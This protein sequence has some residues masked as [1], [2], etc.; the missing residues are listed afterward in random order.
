MHTDLEFEL[1]IGR[2]RITETS[3]TSQDVSGVTNSLTTRVTKLL[4]RRM[5]QMNVCVLES[6]CLDL[7]D[8]YC[9]SL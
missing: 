3:C 2:I 9:L 5:A 6:L 4:L 1:F 8:F 7:R